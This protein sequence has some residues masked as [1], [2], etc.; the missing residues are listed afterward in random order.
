MTRSARPTPPK[1]PRP[2]SRWALQ[3]AKA[4][5]SELVRRVRSEGP[6]HV[7]IHGR[8]EVVVVAADEFRRLEGERTGEALI[9][10]MQSSP[11]RDI[12][13]EPKREQAPVR[14]V[15]L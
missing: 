10:A 12:D 14:D 9:A 5:F 4:R 8:D 13:I 2:P 6:Q 11:Y 7:T 1:P 3:D 15:E